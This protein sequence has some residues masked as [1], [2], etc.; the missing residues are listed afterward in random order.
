MNTFFRTGSLLVKIAIIILFN[1]NYENKTTNDND[2]N[3][4]FSSNKRVIGLA[5]IKQFKK[6]GV[7]SKEMIFS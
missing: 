1:D 2:V 5:P 3:N 6:T 7:F 4:A